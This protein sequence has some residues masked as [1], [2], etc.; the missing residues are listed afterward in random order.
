MKAKLLKII[1]EQKHISFNYGDDYTDIER[2]IVSEFSD[3]EEMDD[4]KISDLKNF[5]RWENEKFQ[6]QGFYYL[7]VLD[8]QQYTAQMAID[9]MREEA[10]KL[11]LKFQ[12]EEAARRQ[13]EEEVKA[14][15]NET[16]KARLLK[17]L[18]KLNEQNN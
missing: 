14:K 17:Q 13:K 3:W 9:D 4:D 1:T 15:R 5:L 2:H 11:R 7:L 16:K 10:R 18:A 6:K 12:E 8:N